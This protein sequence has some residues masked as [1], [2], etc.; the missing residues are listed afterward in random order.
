MLWG[1][2]TFSSNSLQQS[3]LIALAPALAGASVALNTSTIYLGPAVGAAT[4]GFLIN[5]DVI[6]LIPWA[7]AAFLIVAIAATLIAPRLA[8]QK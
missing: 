4:G 1:L 3:R 7:G 2:G 6:T 8:S 5:H